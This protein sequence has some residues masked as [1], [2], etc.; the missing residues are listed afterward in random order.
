MAGNSRSGRRRQ[1]EAIRAMKGS[2]TRSYHRDEPKYSSAIIEIPSI[3]ATDAIAV[4]KWNILNVRLSQSKVLTE[5]DVEMLALLC[6]A[7]SDLERMREQYAAMNYQPLVVD[8][9]R[10]D[11]GE[12][13]QRIKPN[14]LIAL[15]R[16]ASLRVSRFLGEFGLTPMTRAKVGA[17]SSSEPEDAFAKFLTGDSIYTDHADPH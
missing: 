9:I 4:S 1:P 5:A 15:I 8:E 6:M 10:A 2:K 3:I 17:S 7:W 14:P 12:T 16:D 11:N 13:R